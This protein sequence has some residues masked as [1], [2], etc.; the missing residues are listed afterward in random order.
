M[1]IK[2]IAGIAQV[3]PSTVSEVLNGKGRVSA[4]TRANVLA[5]A[6][7]VG[8]RPNELARALRV[9]QTRT[10]GLIIPSVTNPFYPSVARGAE[11][12]AFAAGYDLLLC[13][14]DRDPAKEQAY[15]A[16]LLDKWIDV[17]IFAAPIVGP[18]DL[19]KARADRTAVVLMN[20]SIDDPEVDEIWVDYRG[21]ARSA[22]EFLIG[23]GH[24]RIGFIGG[25]LAIKR[26]GDRL[27]GYREA[28]AL[29]GLL[30]ERL[31]RTGGYD[32]D[33]GYA[34]GRALIEE[35]ARPTAL[36]CA[37][38]MIAIGALAA[39][40]DLGLRVPDDL[41]IVGFDDIPLASLVRPQLTTVYQPSY[42]AGRLAVEMALRRIRGGSGQPKQRRY[43]AKGL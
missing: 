21:A 29:R 32:H 31:I 27:D 25:P 42:E 18:D 36:F 16:S 13:N 23:L 12:A 30:A 5:V 1:T 8:Y 35:L 3:S 19:L 43:L 33:T 6:Q 38:D 41:S 20:C 2:G 39:A 15:I 28:L 24:E 11:D 37:N 22:V 26:F 40:A 7:A 10:I 34:M 14:S 4:R 17:I 9:R